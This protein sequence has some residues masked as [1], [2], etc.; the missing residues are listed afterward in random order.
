MHADKK[1]IENHELRIEKDFS[2]RALDADCESFFNSPFQIL[3]SI[4]VHPRA[5]AVPTS[6][7][8]PST[9]RRHL[10]QRIIG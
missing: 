7:S 4:R 6:S 5:S 9:L 1:R 3:H 10:R 2:A 8:I